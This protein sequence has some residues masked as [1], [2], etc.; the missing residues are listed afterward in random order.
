MPICMVLQERENKTLALIF[1]CLYLS[2]AEKISGSS[3]LHDASRYI[4]LKGAATFAQTGPE[5]LL[6]PPCATLH[7]LPALPRCSHP[8]GCT[9]LSPV[10][11]SP[12]S[13]WGLGLLL[14]RD[15]LG[16]RAVAVRAGEAKLFLKAT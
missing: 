6:T 15:R 4:P 8:T 12:A 1:L 5:A 10:L 2:G 9:A 7:H 11:S 13:T 14:V 16:G 3:A